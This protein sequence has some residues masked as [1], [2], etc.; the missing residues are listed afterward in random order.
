MAGALQQASLPRAGLED[1][2]TAD[3]TGGCS[4]ERMPQPS[5]ALRVAWGAGTQLSNYFAP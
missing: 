3:T 2:A 1:T 5:L 4:V